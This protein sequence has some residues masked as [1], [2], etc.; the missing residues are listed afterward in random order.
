VPG[1]LT[2]ALLAEWPATG[3]GMGSAIQAAYAQVRFSMVWSAVVVVTAV[4]LGL[5]NLV[6]IAETLVLA[7]MG[8]S[9]GRGG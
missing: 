6:Q 1:G 3:D 4:S 2:G 9:P 5:Y 7:R 8:M